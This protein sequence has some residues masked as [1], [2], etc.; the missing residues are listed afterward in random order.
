M[1]VSQE[2]GFVRS[3]ELPH[4][5]EDLAEGSAVETVA[6]SGPDAPIREATS[7]AR[8]ALEAFY[9]GDDAGAMAALHGEASDG[10]TDDDGADGD[11]SNA[12]PEPPASGSEEDGQ[13]AAKKPTR[14]ERQEAARARKAADATD[15]PDEPGAET[16]PSAPEEIAR[17]ARELA[18]QI[19][20]ER[21]EAAKAT[22]ATE[23]AATSR[24]TKVA[25]MIGE[26]P[27][28]AD[29]NVTQYA[30][31]VQAT[32]ARDWDTL[33]KYGIVYGDL[34]GALDLQN[35]LEAQRAAWTDATVIADQLAEKKAWSSLDAQ[36][37]AIGSMPGV[38]TAKFLAAGIGPQALINGARVAVET[39]VAAKD[40]EWQT[41]HAAAEKAWTDKVADLEGRLTE[42]TTRGAGRRPAPDAGGRPGTPAGP[43]SIEQI[44]SLPLAEKKKHLDEWIAAI[45]R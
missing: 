8:S 6:V 44:R 23:S 4:M 43:L 14:K 45:P 24:V 25:E 3:W 18:E 16:A 19:V 9:A 12:S 13:D 35:A 30:E 37:T 26:A 20:R 39:A 1:P 31:L 2:A 15:T 21:D 41:K 36:F 32:R 38:D 10:D 27:G 7:T 29:P 22:Q 28:R 17:Q 40:A 11:E 42:A 33:D 5:A 34:D